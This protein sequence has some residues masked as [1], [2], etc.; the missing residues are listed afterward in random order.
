M[1]NFGKFGIEMNG[2]EIW[3]VMDYDWIR[4]N[5]GYKIIGLI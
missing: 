3:E 2:Y 4:V 5:I 1:D